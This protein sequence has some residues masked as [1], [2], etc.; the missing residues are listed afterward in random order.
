MKSI[1]FIR[2]NIILILQ[3]L[4]GFFLLTRAIIKIILSF[5]K[6]KDQ[7]IFVAWHWSFGHQ[8]QM[9]ECVARV[10]KN[11]DKIFLFQTIYLKRNNEF[12]TNLY[13]KFY[14]LIDTF[15]S[16]NLILCKTNYLVYKFIFKF[17]L[18][19]YIKEL[20]IYEEFYQEYK[21]IYQIGKDKNIHHYDENLKKIIT[22]YPL[23][24]WVDKIIENYPYTHKL[25][26]TL[27]DESEAL[28]L[29]MKIDLNKK[30]VSFFFRD[31]QESGTYYDIIRNSYNILNYTESIKYFSQANYNV[32][33]FGPN[34]N[35]DLDKL[36][37]LKIKNAYV[38]PGSLNEDFK[39]INIYA[40]FKSEK[41]ISQNSA[42]QMLAGFLSKDGYVV[43]YCPPF[44][45]FPNK[46][47][48]IMP[49]INI[50]K[51][52]LYF[53]DY[54]DT[55]I[56]WGKEFNN[57]HCYIEANSENEILNFLSKDL[58]KVNKINN[59]IPSGSAFKVREHNTLYCSSYFK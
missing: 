12:L 49:K 48:I 59:Q 39:K 36:S 25:K 40:I 24:I 14:N 5:N 55:D 37:N 32:F 53:K 16:N 42:P 50:N 20:I 26:K 54:K 44:F 9:L 13:D 34:Q 51:K 23:Q 29:K 3:F 52:I 21:S 22:N 45:G 18:K 1:K 27:V 41:I 6:F 33:I 15:K 43:D 47:K 19:S 31:Y 10:Y 28:L 56:F 8:A 2:N 4:F 7:T 46:V 57:E 35:K 11:Q 58:T 17:L 30:I 38:F